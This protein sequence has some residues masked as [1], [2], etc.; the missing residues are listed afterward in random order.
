MSD[1]ALRIEQ[2]LDVDASPAVVWQVITDL[3]RYGEWNPFVVDC[4][5]SLVVGDPIVMRV[6]VFAA[7]AQTQRETILEHTPG[8]RLCY[9]IAGSALGSLMS[10]RCH[11]VEALA[12]GRTRYRSRFALRGWV[13]PVVAG[14]LGGRLERGFAG[15]S[16]ALAA[17][18]ASIGPGT[19]RAGSIATCVARGAND[20][21][22]SDRGAQA[23]VRS[24]SR[25]R[26]RAER[27]SAVVQT[28]AP[29]S[30]SAGVSLMTRAS[31]SATSACLVCA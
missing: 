8:A 7:F 13:A 30:A 21:T 17:R 12:D 4:R 29:A 5:S 31:A 22:C 28:A 3:P 24:A 25:W 11:E 14:L 27:L 16:A 20:L 23:R 9:G 26:A 10:R 6:H 18:A 2:T 1:A 15:M 19:V